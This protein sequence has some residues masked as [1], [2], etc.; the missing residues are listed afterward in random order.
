MAISF[1]ANSTTAVLVY[2][3]ATTY[4]V[5]HTKLAWQHTSA[6][7]KLDLLSALILVFGLQQMA[8]VGARRLPHLVAAYACLYAQRSR[9]SES[10]PNAAEQQIGSKGDVQFALLRWL[11]QRLVLLLTLRCHAL[12]LVVLLVARFRLFV[13]CFA[14]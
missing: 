6:Q 11:R 3:A 1:A 14:V 4:L 2:V 10:L 13:C 5:E 9:L 12:G 8:E 7:T